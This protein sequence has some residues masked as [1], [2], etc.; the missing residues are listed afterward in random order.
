MPHIL[1]PERKMAFILR[2]EPQFGAINTTQGSTFWFGFEL[3]F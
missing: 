3:K 2:Y 1:I